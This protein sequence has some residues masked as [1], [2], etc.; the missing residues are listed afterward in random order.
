MTYVKETI[1]GDGKGCAIDTGLNT[2]SDENG[3]KLHPNPVN[4]FSPFKFHLHS[5]MSL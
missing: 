3:F 5:L 2:F 4:D 1:T